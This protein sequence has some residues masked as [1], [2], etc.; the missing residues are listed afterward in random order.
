VARERARLP[1]KTGFCGKIRYLR[2]LRTCSLETRRKP[3]PG[4]S[5]RALVHRPAVDATC[6]CATAPNP[7]RIRHIVRGAALQCPTEKF[8][9]WAVKNC[10]HGT[11]PFSPDQ[12]PTKCPNEAQMKRRRRARS[13]A[14]AGQTRWTSTRSPTIWASLRTNSRTSSRAKTRSSRLVSMADQTPSAR[15]RKRVRGPILSRI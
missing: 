11:P 10:D 12:D 8:K 4:Q 1:S 9:I 14:V 7:K 3:D 13:R 2:E 6:D 5:V 15:P